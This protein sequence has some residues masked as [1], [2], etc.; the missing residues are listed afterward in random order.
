[1]SLLLSCNIIV[2]LKKIR[3]IFIKTLLR[4]NCYYYYTEIRI[5]GKIMS[6]KTTQKEALEY[7][8][9]FSTRIECGLAHVYELIYYYRYHYHYRYCFGLINGAPKNRPPPHYNDAHTLAYILRNI[10]VNIVIICAEYT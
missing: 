1:M 8:S 2:V 9:K 4:Y 7:T 5:W 10:G 6:T 3:V